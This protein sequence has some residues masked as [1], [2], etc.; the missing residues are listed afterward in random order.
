MIETT[1]MLQTGGP[2]AKVHVKRFYANWPDVELKGCR[3]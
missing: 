1:I 2:V 3:A